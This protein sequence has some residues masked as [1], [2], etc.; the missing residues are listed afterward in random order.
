MRLL[1]DH[2]TLVLAETPDIQLD[3]VPGLLW[4]PRV[5]LFR[6]P[7]HRYVDV[8]DALRSRGIVFR[9]EVRR[10]LMAPPGSWDFGELRP[11]QRAALFSWELGGCR[12]IVVMPTGSGKTR[13]AM[14]VLA[15]AGSRALCLVPTRALLQQ[16]LV[17]LSAVYTGP[18]GRLGDG[19]FSV[20]SITVATFES[21]YRHMPRMG[22]QFELLIVD[23]VHHFGTGM[24]DETL[25]MCVAGQRLGLTA[26]PPG[27]SALVALEHLVGPVNYELRVG[28]LAG[29][30][31]ADFD[32]VAIHVGL[33]R[34]ERAAYAADQRL[35]SDVNRRFRQLHSQGTWQ[36][37][38]SAASQSPEGRAALS[39]WRRM[40]RLV[41]FTEAKAEAVRVLLARHPGSRVLVFTADNAAAYAI[42][43]EHL[44]MPITCDISRS[45][46][47]RALAAFRSG[48]LR[49]LVSARVLNEGIDVPEADVAI[50]VGGTQGEREHVQRVGRLLRP[51]AGKR[52]MVYELVTVATSEVRKA[53]ERRRGLAAASVV[54]A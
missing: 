3:F 44:I 18:I 48:E 11:Y 41:G 7:A 31:L 23:E 33:N 40:R 34:D 49:A 51:S 52:A 37:F 13:V 46:R 30:W 42:A 2:G 26:T 10:E 27:Q 25:E 17:E 38:V 54:P 4:D 43:R 36:E 50:I 8:L 53:A 47:E 29:R 21:A 32:L 45:E 6:A 16:W 1:F 9:N 19:H 12:G 15:A 20:E 5:G 39:A 28:D 24:R 22:H 14:A 35:F